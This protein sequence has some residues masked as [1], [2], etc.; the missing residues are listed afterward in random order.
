MMPCQYQGGGED[1]VPAAHQ[2]RERA[3][4]QQDLRCRDYEAIGQVTGLR[5]EAR[6]PSALTG[7]IPDGS[8]RLLEIVRKVQPEAAVTARYREAGG[9]FAIFSGS[10]VTPEG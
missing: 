1:H 2:Q 9:R 6:L 3:R 8:S 10:S 7:S 4:N 5:L